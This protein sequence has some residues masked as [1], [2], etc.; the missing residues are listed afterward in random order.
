MCTG[1]IILICPRRPDVVL[2]LPVDKGISSIP[3]FFSHAPQRSRRSRLHEQRVSGRIRW[4]RR[5]GVYGGDTT[6][7]LCSRE[8]AWRR[9]RAATWVP[10]AACA[11]RLLF[12]GSRHGSCSDLR[13]PPIPAAETVAAMGPTRGGDLSLADHGQKAHQ[14]AKPRGQASHGTTPAI[15][16]SERAIGPTERRKPFREI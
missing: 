5:W 3:L 7:L 16:A 6:G 11:P 9:S 13:L 8:G 4:R 12:L 1:L 2:Q 15:Q 10:L 14:R